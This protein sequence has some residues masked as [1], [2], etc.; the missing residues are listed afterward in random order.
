MF[1]KRYIYQDL[2]DWK[3]KYAGHYSLLIEGPRRVGKSTL[4]LE[5]AK[6]EYENYIFIDFS[7]VGKEILSMFDDI[8]NL[9][10]FFLRISTY[11][12]VKLIPGRTLFVFDEVQ[13]FPK[14]RQ[15]LKHLTLDGRYHY[16]E[17]GSLISIHK[18][19]KDILIPSEEKRL[20]MHPMS[21]FEFNEAIGDNNNE[22]F[23][24]IIERNKPIGD[25]LNQELMKRFRIY[26]A[27]GGMPQA[28]ETYIK[29]NNLLEVDSV[30]RDILSLYEQDFYKIDPSG[31]LSK[32]FNNIPS[33]L[34]L[35]K[36]RFVLSFA[37]KKRTTQ[38]DESFLSMLIDSKTVLKCEN[39][40]DPFS[41]LFQTIDMSQYKLYL[42]DT[43]LFISMLYKQRN[44]EFMSNI[45]SNLLEN[46]LPENLG[47]LFENVVAQTLSSMNIPLYY[48][49][50]YK[51]GHKRPYEIDFI[52]N[53][54][55]DN[56]IPIEV[57]SNSVKNYKSLKEFC[58]SKKERIKR[59]WLFSQKDIKHIDNIDFYPFY[60]IHLLF[61]KNR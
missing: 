23:K 42:A 8:Y 33:Q 29:T 26:M 41:S 12:K 53:D 59:G 31:R 20:E 5:F 3:R 32:L 30:K 40:K 22:N 2:L 27:V 16:I 56:L 34:A 46:K 47:F 60:L 17:T 51:A 50:F 10:I 54:G 24:Q 35:G 36:K 19:V 38:R 21:Y 25:G 55:K 52:F 45:Y 4:V 49:I 6:R 44:D 9:N 7:T 11:F 39:S 48:H 28:V 58:D 13:F 37:L 14:A 61:S 1:F 18:N 57:K 43:G 15:A